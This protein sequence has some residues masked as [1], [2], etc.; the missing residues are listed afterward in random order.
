MCLKFL[1]IFSI[2]SNL[3]QYPGEKRASMEVCGS[4]VSFLEKDE[5]TTKI[6]GSGAF[7]TIRHAIT[8]LNPIYQYKRRLSTVKAMAGV[9]CGAENKDGHEYVI[10]KIDYNR[11]AVDCKKRSPDS[12]FAIVTVSNCHY[13]IYLFTRGTIIFP[14]NLIEL[15]IFC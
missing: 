9:Y 4:V 7:L 13:I 1:N 14:E 10:Q 8:S 6:I 15:V 5:F 2:E 3:T 12:Q 11:Y